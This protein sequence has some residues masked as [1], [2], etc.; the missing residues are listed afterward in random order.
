MKKEVI[1]MNIN[2]KVVGQAIILGIQL[3]VSV[4][5]I[6]QVKKLVDQN[7]EL[8]AIVAEKIKENNAV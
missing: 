8:K 1:K 3:A 2:K 5:A 7:R 6:I 4:R